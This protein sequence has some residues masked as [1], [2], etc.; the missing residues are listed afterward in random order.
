MSKILDLVL[1]GTPA[2]FDNDT[3]L[4]TSEFV[5]RA[6]GNMSAAMTVSAS[7]SLDATAAG[8]L[9]Q[10]AGAGGY[11]ITLPA[12]TGL[13][14]GTTIELA[15]SA[16]GT[17]TIQRAESDGIYPAMG[18]SVTSFAMLAGDTAVLTLHSNGVWCLAGG[19]V[20]L[21]THPQFGASIQRPGWQ[22]LPS[23]LI[24]QWGTSTASSSSAGVSTSFPT[25]FP[26]QC[27]IVTLTPSASSNGYIPSLESTSTTGFSSSMYSNNTTRA[28]G[29]TAYY[30][31]L[32]Y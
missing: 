11:T 8:K 24:V 28:A 17:N 22:K 2:Q 16:S 19:S 5:Q 15:C 7:S 31:A 4:A 25:N 1:A 10:I 14:P 9:V 26:N 12:T 13:L 18:G 6:A 23:G 3:S 32:G 30:L 20:L 29:V 21:K 27:M